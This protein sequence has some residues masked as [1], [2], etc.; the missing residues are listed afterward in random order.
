MLCG[1]TKKKIHEARGKTKT[2]AAQKR[3]ATV[4]RFKD[5]LGRKSIQ[6]NDMRLFTG[7]WEVLL[8]WIREKMK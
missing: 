5:K 4:H 1:A 2:E 7:I 6:K 3:T 8:T